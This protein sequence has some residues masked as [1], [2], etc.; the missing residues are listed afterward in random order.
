MKE[1]GIRIGLLTALVSPELDAV[2]ATM[3]SLGWTESELEPKFKHQNISI[4]QKNCGGTVASVF[5]TAINEMGQ[6]HSAVATAAFLERVDPNFIFLCGICGS[7]NKEK[8]EKE[9]VI[10]A[11]NVFWKGFNKI[12]D[13]PLFKCFRAKDYIAPSVDDD[14]A[15]WIAKVFSNEINTKRRPYSL[16][17]EDVFTWEFVTTGERATNKVLEMCPSAA[18]VE[19][20]AGGFIKAVESFGRVRERKIPT[21]V[22]RGV[23]DYTIQKDKDQIVRE[24]ASSNAVS[25]VSEL[26]EFFT[27]DKTLLEHY[28][29]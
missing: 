18:C 27:V 22:V 15:L 28:A 12:G 20:E 24:R 25:I 6:T 3:R 8:Y 13:G 26:A 19:M 9:S 14:Y 10:V 4:W 7:L 5:V 23:S 11:K 29:R 16:H 2:P 21:F 1:T 17:F